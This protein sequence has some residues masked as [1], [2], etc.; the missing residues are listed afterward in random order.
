[1]QTFHYIKHTISYNAVDCTNK[2][3]YNSISN[4]YIERVFSLINNLQ[5]DNW[6][7]LSFDMVKAEFIIKEDIKVKC[8]DFY[9]EIK[10]N[11]IY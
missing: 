8:S 4:D 7:R 2:L 9:N 10:N 11:K 6:N 5:S 1:M 3:D